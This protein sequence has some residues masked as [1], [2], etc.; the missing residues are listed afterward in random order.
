MTTCSFCA[1]H[2]IEPMKVRCVIA[3]DGG[4]WWLADDLV[5]PHCGTLTE[6]EYVKQLTYQEYRMFRD[7][8]KA[9]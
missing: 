5:C 4:Y 7:A 9:A 2:Y 3:D 6:V 1:S 8:E